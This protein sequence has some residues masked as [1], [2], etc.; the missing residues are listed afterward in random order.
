M[1]KIMSEKDKSIMD[2]KSEIEDSSRHR[3]GQLEQLLW[4]DSMV[5]EKDAKI[6]DRE[7]AI[8]AMGVTLSDQ[9]T[10]INTLQAKLNLQ[11]NLPEVQNWRSAHQQQ[12]EK[13]QALYSHCRSLA[14]E[15]DKLRD[16][17]SALSICEAKTKELSDQ[18]QK[19]T[20][21]L[22]ALIEKEKKTKFING[23]HSLDYSVTQPTPAVRHEMADSMS[24][25]RK[26]DITRLSNLV[27]TL[28]HK[29]SPDMNRYSQSNT[30]NDSEQV[31]VSNPDHLPPAVPLEMYA[32]WLHSHDE[33]LT[34]EEAEQYDGYLVRQTRPPPI[35]SPNL[36]KP[37][38][39]WMRFNPNMRRNLP[40]P[41]MC[42]KLGC[43][44]DPNFY[45]LTV[46][47]YNYTP[48]TRHYTDQP[49]TPVFEKGE[50]FGSEYGFVTEMGVMPVPSYPI[51]GFVFHGGSWV[52]ASGH[53]GG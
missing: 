17:I 5:N 41:M 4:L 10:T 35:Y 32:I 25:I 28:A 48:Y 45:N 7:L 13:F 23:S 16:H 47:T 19:L 49:P 51:H 11:N 31:C 36:P 18:Q 3:E 26:E 27:D 44:Q 38:V 8:Y 1:T 46:P 29:Y 12:D 34:V 24:R 30:T 14:N 40:I 43:S 22:L 9:T 15:R 2:L 42:P 37:Y 53:Y 21:S 52:I 20:K 50:P 33:D 6:Y 39:N